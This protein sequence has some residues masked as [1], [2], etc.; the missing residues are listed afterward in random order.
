M[1]LWA[2]HLHLPPASAKGSMAPCYLGPSI[3]LTLPPPIPSLG[4][5]PKWL[6]RE[7][8]AG[9][10][11]HPVGTGE[12]PGHSCFGNVFGLGIWWTEGREMS[13]RGHWGLGPLTGHLSKGHVPRRGIRFLWTQCARGGRGSRLSS[14]P[15]AGEWVC[16]LPPRPRAPSAAALAAGCAGTSPHNSAA[17]ASGTR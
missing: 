16:W 11:G 2:C 1:A 12:E 7:P 5:G 3:P 8:V 9:L 14:P 4:G 10:G 6:P 17:A 13:G 15:R